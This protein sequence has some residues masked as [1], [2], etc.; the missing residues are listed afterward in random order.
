LEHDKNRGLNAAI[1]TGF[2][3][4]KGR[5]VAKLDDD[6]ELAEF[7]ITTAIDTFKSV[8]GSNIGLLFFNCLDVETKSTS[9]KFL[10]SQ[11]IIRYEDLLRG[12]LQGDYWAVVDSSVLHPYE[13]LDEN[14][15]GGMGC[16]WLRV[17]HRCDAYYLPKTVYFTYRQHEMMRLT[18]FSSRRE[19]WQ[20]HEDTTAS[21]LAE[22]GKDMK[23]VSPQTYARH[24]RILAFYQLM[25]RKFDRARSNLILSL[26]TN[27]SLSASALLVLSFVGKGRALFFIYRRLLENRF[28]KRLF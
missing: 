5:Y 22:F 17:L 1:N 2:Q 13:M 15:W 4:A 9:G 19:N 18:N 21:L 28:I 27:M 3:K 7:A 12:A 11:K 24:I 10:P 14:L 23:L 8:H 6:D 20:R 26:R 16:L 25:N